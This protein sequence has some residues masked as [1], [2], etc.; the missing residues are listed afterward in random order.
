MYIVFKSQTVLQSLLRK[1]AI[2]MPHA[3]PLFYPI[4]YSSVNTKLFL[5]I[6]I[7]DDL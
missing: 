1:P 3:S 4:P 5:H 7:Q 6:P 2:S